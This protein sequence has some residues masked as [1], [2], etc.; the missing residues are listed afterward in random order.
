MAT[1]VF[2]APVGAHTS[3]LSR[4][5]G[6]IKDTLH[7]IERRYPRKGSCTMRIHNFR[8]DQ[9]LVVT[10]IHRVEEQEW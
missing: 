6:R 4:G 8:N 9:T 7:G 5:K 10:A 3:I 1:L 2:P